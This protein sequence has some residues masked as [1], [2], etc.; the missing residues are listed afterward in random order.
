MESGK[1]QIQELFRFVN[2]GYGVGDRVAGYFTGCDMAPAFY[3]ELR[4]GSRE[5][6]MSIFRVV[7]Q[8]AIQAVRDEDAIFGERP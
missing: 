8:E 3:E 2:T 5:L 4:T 1:I 7:G 6:D